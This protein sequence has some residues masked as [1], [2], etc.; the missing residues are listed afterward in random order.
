MFRA[1]RIALLAAL[2][3]LVPAGVA[4]AASPGTNPRANY[5]APPM[6]AACSV[7]TSAVC[8]RAAV[9]VLD[10]A[11]ASLGQPPYS[12]PSN[13]TALTPAEQAFVL[14]NLDRVQ[15]GLAP[16]TGLSLALNA[17]ALTGVRQDADPQPTATDY[18]A[19]TS[20]WAG[21]F[22]NMPLAYEAWMYDDG[23][24]SGNLDCTRSN[25]GGCWGHRQD[26]LYR[27]DTAGA[28]AMGAAQGTDSGQRPGYAMLLFEGDGTFRP[29]YTYTWS[30]A[31]AAGAGAGGST[32]GPG[33]G[34]QGPA[35]GAPR[36]ASL[37]ITR[38]L[39]HGRRVT[40][41]VSAPWSA[42]A[43]CALTPPARHGWAR[44]RF[45]SCRAAIILAGHHGERY[46]LRVRAGGTL[47][48][49]Y[50]RVP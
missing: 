20:N 18:L 4:A 16:V 43:Q 39:V 46:R 25:P 11:R 24:G 26:V 41:T 30:E 33:A 50:V 17:N 19:W 47:L 9:D 7:P 32:S 2:L 6:P 14:A 31:L 48:T 28:L 44:D 13:F 23:P 15:Y 29:T 22:P 45:R 8:I 12:L 34:A 3:C 40:V 10:H 38:V 37:P 42:T 21:G 27:F 5:P 35:S 1:A 49:R 36:T